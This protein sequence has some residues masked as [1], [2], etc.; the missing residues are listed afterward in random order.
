MNG[1]QLRRLSAVEAARGVQK[2]EEY[3]FSEF[4]VAEML[5]LEGY[6]ERQIAGEEVDF[7]QLPVEILEKI[8]RASSDSELKS[9]T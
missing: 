9:S 6:L 5:V 4:S 1:S 2:D 3:D 8:A 7:S